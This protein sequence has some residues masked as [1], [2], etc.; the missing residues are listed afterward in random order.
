LERVFGAGV[1]SKLA[2]FECA[3]RK[4]QQLRQRARECRVAA[5]R[6]STSELR[7]HYANL[8]AVWEKLADERVAFFIQQPEPE[9]DGETKGP[10]RTA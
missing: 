5:N 3:L 10:R 7:T 1:S 4:V 8:A 9:T 2:I 6:A